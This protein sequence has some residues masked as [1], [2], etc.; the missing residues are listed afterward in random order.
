MFN[1]GNDLAAYYGGDDAIGLSANGGSDTTPYIVL[2]LDSGQSITAH[3]GGDPGYSTRSSNECTRA[4]LDCGKRERVASL[5]SGYNGVHAT[6]A[7]SD[8]W[9]PSDS[10]LPL[11][12]VRVGDANVLY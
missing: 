4:S 9:F 3:N 12:A 7:C 5:W 10:S 8:L 6:V 2:E 11:G 1:T